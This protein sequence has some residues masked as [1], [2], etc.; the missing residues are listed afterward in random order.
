M[1]G[2]FS[3]SIIVKQNVLRSVSGHLNLEYYI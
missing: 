3:T 2:A 1:I